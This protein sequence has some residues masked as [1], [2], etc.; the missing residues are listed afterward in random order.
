MGSGHGTA[1][2]ANIR[3]KQA[4]TQ[5]TSSAKSTPVKPVSK[6]ANKPA[7]IAIGENATSVVIK[8]NAS[9]SETSIL[10]TPNNTTNKK[11]GRSFLGIIRIVRTS[12][13]RQVIKPLGTAEKRQKV[14]ATEGDSKV[15]R[16]PPVSASSSALTERDSNGS[17]EK[18]CEISIRQGNQPIFAMPGRT[19]RSQEG[20]TS[21]P[22]TVSRNSAA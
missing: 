14:I 6:S 4:S 15:S 2:T 5:R 20:S 19:T 13:N 8:S 11:P 9:E 12:P 22:T 17:G 7:S 10:T 16:N 21:R 3:S 1:Q 18:S